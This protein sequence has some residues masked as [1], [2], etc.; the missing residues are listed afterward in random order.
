MVWQAS[1]GDR[2]PYADHVVIPERWIWD[3]QVL[4]WACFGSRLHGNAGF[5]RSNSLKSLVQSCRR[6]R[7]DV[8]ADAVPELIG[9]RDAS[10]LS[11]FRPR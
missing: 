10:A 4:G 11:A 9:P 8:D 5:K 6:I 1:A 2:R 7:I 3:C